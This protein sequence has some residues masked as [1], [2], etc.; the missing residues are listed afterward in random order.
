MKCGK[1]FYL[2]PGIDGKMHGVNGADI[3]SLFTGKNGGDDALVARHGKE[4]ITL[5]MPAGTIKRYFGKGQE[6]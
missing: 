4:W 3:D 5:A 2:L 6:T 1:V